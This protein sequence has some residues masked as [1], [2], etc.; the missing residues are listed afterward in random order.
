MSSTTS[1]AVFVVL[2]LAVIAALAAV[3]FEVV[4][5]HAKRYARLASIAIW[6]VGKHAAAP[7]PAGHEVRIGV[8]VDEMAGRSDLR[9]GLLARQVTAGVG[10]RCIKLQGLQR[11]VFEVRHSG[12]GVLGIKI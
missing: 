3:C 5:G 11:Q 9:A 12:I 10:R 4:N 7:E 1:I 6:A 8:V 2:D